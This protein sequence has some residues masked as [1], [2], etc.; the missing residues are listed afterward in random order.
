MGH[1]ATGVTV[2]TTLGTEPCG[3]TVNA[4]TSVSLSPPLVLVCLRDD[5]RT[6]AALLDTG[7]FGVNVLHQ[8]QQALAQHFARRGA[9]WEGVEHTE[10]AAAG[11]PLIAGAV[12]TLECAV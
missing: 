7:R 9:S 12:A 10:G 1:F 2:I 4:I 6:L 11:V 3:S 5:S 8:R